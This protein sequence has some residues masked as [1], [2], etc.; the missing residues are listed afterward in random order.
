MDSKNIFLNGR[1]V[2]FE[3]LHLLEVCAYKNFFLFGVVLKLQED[4]DK[5]VKKFRESVARIAPLFD[6]LSKQ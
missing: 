5:L 6:E 2:V 3:R 1:I 4:R